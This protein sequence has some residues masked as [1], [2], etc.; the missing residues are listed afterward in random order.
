MKLFETLDDVLKIVGEDHPYAGRPFVLSAGDEKPELLLIKPTPSYE[1]LKRNSIWSGD[2]GRLIR[3]AVYNLGK[4][5][6]F[7]SLTPFI[8]DGNAKAKDIEQ[9][10]LY[11]AELIR[12]S[13][14]KD[15][16]LFG[17][18]SARYCRQLGLKFQRFNDI[19]GKVYEVNEYRFIAFPHPAIYARTPTLYTELQRK[20]QEFVTPLTKVE[21]STSFREDYRM[22]KT[23]EEAEKILPKLGQRLAVDIESTGLDYFRDRILTIQFSDTVGEGHSFLWEVQTPEE[24]ARFLRHKHLVLQNGSFDAKFLAANGVH[25]KISEDTMLMHSLIDE[26]PGT[27]SMDAMADRYLKGVEKWSDLVNYDDMESV[28]IDVLGRYGARDTDLTL[29]LANIFQPKVRGLYINTVLHD[30]QNAIVAAELRGIKVD[31]EKAFT[32]QEEIEK[33]LHDRKGYMADV[34]GLQN[35]N[36]PKQVAEVLAAMD[37]P[38]QKV[39]GKVSTNEASLNALGDIPIARDILEYRHLTKASGTY[40]RNILDA[41]ERDG[42]YHPEFRLANTETGR[43]AEPLIM[44]IPRPDNVEGADL[45]KQY[46][47]RLREL[48]IPDDGM[49]MVGADYSGLEVSMAAHIS[50]DVQLIRDVVNNVDIHSVVAIQAFDLDEPEQPYDTLKSRVSSRY[51]YERTLAKAGVFAWL[52]G[53]DASTIARNLNIPLE[54]ARKIMDAL[55]SRYSGVAEW[56]EVTRMEAKEKGYVSTPWGRSRRF[57]FNPTFSNQVI[58]AQYRESTNMPIQ[59][60]ASD[61]NLK[62][63]AT[64]H[65]QGVQTLFPFHDAIYCQASDYFAESLAELMRKTMEQSLPGPVPFRVDVKIGDNWGELG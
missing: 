60:M 65:K 6:Y 22:Y 41:T 31:R 21:S 17:S 10:E 52:Y 36:S 49:K 19:V 63:F 18:D 15:V 24:W 62:A 20:L 2:E 11:L 39:Q 35:A 55:Q 56:Q 4:K 43:L 38:L 51:G 37:I 50:G 13:G 45:G 30:A 47:Y 7:G 25:V 53:G 54:L 9:Y 46:Q 61:M 3:M 5:A 28:D 57:N 8:P 44:L 48:F 29:R 59:G 26:T 42:R 27:H 32:F 23:R 16:V 1:D 12:R 14:A 34:Y 33:A 40:L 64:L 58:L